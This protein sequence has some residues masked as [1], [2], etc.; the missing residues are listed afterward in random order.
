[1]FHDM[2]TDLTLLAAI[3]FNSIH[4]AQIGDSNVNGNARFHPKQKVD[5]PRQSRKRRHHNET[6]V[7][8]GEVLGQ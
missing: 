6:Q 3:Q 8:Y 2:F 5:V 4:S 1:M 7:R